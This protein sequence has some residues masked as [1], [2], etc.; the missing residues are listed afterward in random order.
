MGLGLP[1][2]AVAEGTPRIEIAGVTGARCPGCERPRKEEGK[3]KRMGKERKER[4]KE[5]AKKRKKGGEEKKR[6]GGKRKREG[7]KKKE[8]KEKEKGEGRKKKRK[9]RKRKE[10][11]LLVPPGGG[12]SA[13]RSR[14]E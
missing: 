7:G 13:K 8:E 3:R 14:R 6:R 12:V 9:G 1:C 4:G 10:K 11:F 2:G 5:K